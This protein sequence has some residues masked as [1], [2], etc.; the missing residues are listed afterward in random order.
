MRPH[1]TA[2]FIAPFAIENPPGRE[3][4]A[5]GRCVQK[6]MTKVVACGRWD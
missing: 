4:G 6:A 5:F 3:L 2:F 1:T